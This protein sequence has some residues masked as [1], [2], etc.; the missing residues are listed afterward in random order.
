[1]LEHLSSKFKMAP[2]EREPRAALILNRFTRSLQIMYATQSVS[3]VLGLPPEELQDRPFYCCIQAN[4]LADAA[5]CLESA[6]QNDSIA[7]LRF[8]FRD[9][10]TVDDEGNPIVNNDMDGVDGADGNGNANGQRH[11]SSPSDSEGGGAPLDHEMAVDSDSPGSTAPALVKQEATADQSMDDLVPFPS[12][13]ASSMSNPLERGAGAFDRHSADMAYQT[14]VTSASSVTATQA[15]VAGVDAALHRQQPRSDVPRRRGE[16][17][18][19]A[20]AQDIELE[21]VVSCTSDGLVVVLR[22]ARPAIPIAD[23]AP[24]K[25][26][27]GLFAAPWAM[28]PVRPQYQA[29]LVHN[30]QAPLLPQYMP[31]QDKVKSSGGPPMDQLMASIRDVAVFAWG[32]VGINGNLTEYAHGSPHGDAQPADLPVWD[33]RAGDTGYHGPENSA[34]TR[35]AQ[36]ARGPDKGKAPERNPQVQRF[37]F[38]FT[39]NPFSRPTEHHFGF[40]SSTTTFNNS[41]TGQDHSTPFI[42]HYTQPLPPYGQSVG[43]PLPRPVNMS[44]AN[45][46][47]G[48]GAN[49]NAMYGN[50]QQNY[51]SAIP[52]QQQQQ[53]QTSIFSFVSAPQAVPQAQTH[54]HHHHHHLHAPQASAA[55]SNGNNSQRET[56]LDTVSTRPHSQG[57]AAPATEPA[58]PGPPQN[59]S[60]LH[61]P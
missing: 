43:Q 41:H 24:V 11:A 33:P 50:P 29:E 59:R 46:S 42:G 17:G 56:W 44:N 48:T 5:D 34:V 49:A 14:S 6:K 61:W 19:R 1:M 57:F 53:Q 13:S 20:A 31:V 30:F 32:L 23:R 38:A 16:G 55:Q 4:C 27:N 2:V 12:T 39:N 54:L 26:E 28:Q 18:R 47:N 60:S 52:Q 3:S 37:D 15:N 21:A 58:S 36:M 40:Q 51:W 8:W 22:R 10:R 35:W 7:Y 9:P 45:Y 25:Y